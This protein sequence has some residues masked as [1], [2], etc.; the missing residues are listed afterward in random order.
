MGRERVW[1]LWKRVWQFLKKIKGKVHNWAN[2]LRIHPI[3]MKTGTWMKTYPHTFI[4]ALFKIASGENKQS[5]HEWRDKPWYT[6]WKINEVLIHATT[7]MN[8]KICEASEVSH[9]RPHIVWFHLCEIYSI[10]K[11][12]RDRELISACQL[13]EGEENENWE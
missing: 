3:K 4:A 12:H 9:K 10:G 6:V 2:P 11:I 1:V 5:Q 8:L 7:W 13:V